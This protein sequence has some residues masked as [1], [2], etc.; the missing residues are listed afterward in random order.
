[1]HYLSHIA[2]MCHREVWKQ[3]A[4]TDHSLIEVGVV[5]ESEENVASQSTVLNP[6][7][8]R[9]VPESFVQM[10]IYKKREYEFF[11]INYV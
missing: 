5:R 4:G 8:L 7:L 10:S 2:S 1:M 11:V 3:S 9:D 6:A